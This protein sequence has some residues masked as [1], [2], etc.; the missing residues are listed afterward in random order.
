MKH[1]IFT[2]FTIFACINMTKAQVTISTSDLNGTEWEYVGSQSDSGIGEYYEYTH[3][4]KIWHRRDGKTSTYLYYLTDTLPTVFDL[5]KVGV[6][7]KGCYYIEYNQ[8]MK[9]F[10]CYSI[11]YFNKTE[12]SMVHKLETKDLIDLTDTIRFKLRKNNS[13]GA[14][15]STKPTK[16]DEPK[17]ELPKEFSL[18]I[19]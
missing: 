9:D 7:T 2:F 1:L 15:S 8:K 17:T 4:S 3:E 13:G 12:G 16:R 6:A 11:Q 18:S 14:T 5:A 10:V 19:K